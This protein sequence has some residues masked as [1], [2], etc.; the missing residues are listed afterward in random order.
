MQWQSG[1]TALA[2]INMIWNKEETELAERMEENLNLES[3]I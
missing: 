2:E 1:F 3:R